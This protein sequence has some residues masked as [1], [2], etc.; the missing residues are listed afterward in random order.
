MHLV[1]D[2]C[3]V[4]DTIWN[5]FNLWFQLRIWDCAYWTYECILQKNSFLI[6]IFLDNRN[7]KQYL[8]QKNLS[9]TLVFRFVF[10]KSSCERVYLGSGVWFSLLVLGF[11][12]S[13]I[14]SK[15]Y[16]F[17]SL[18]NL[19]RKARTKRNEIR[20]DLNSLAAVFVWGALTSSFWSGTQPMSFY[21]TGLESLLLKSH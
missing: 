14:S 8:V 4:F 13:N 11:F 10:F 17:I 21:W 3:P 2:F 12:W 20:E 15:T 16:C 5:Y 18:Q 6:F 1:K 7:I 9:S 19:E